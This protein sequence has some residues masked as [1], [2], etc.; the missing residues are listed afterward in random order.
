MPKKRTKRWFLRGFLCGVILLLLLFFGGIAYMRYEAESLTVNRSEVVSADWTLPPLRVAVVADFHVR[1]DPD[2][3]AR[4][5]TIVARTNAETPDL[6]LLPGDFAAGMRPG[7][8]ADPQEIA[9]ELAKLKAPLGVYAVL[10]NHDHWQKKENFVRAFGR[11]G[12]P[13]L[14][15][16]SVELEFAGKRFHLVGIIDGWTQESPDW[17]TLLPKDQLPRI[18]M[19]HTPDIYDTLPEPTALAVAGHTHGG[20]IVLPF[21]G[22]PLLPSRHHRRYASGLVT[23]GRNNVFITVGTG[24]SIVPLRFL[25]PPEIAILTLKGH[26]P[27]TP[28]PVIV[29]PQQ[30]GR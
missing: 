27:A 16:R 7:K 2:A 6:I 26:L 23:E 5:R 18:V 1:R 15:N 13:L 14:E 24:T 29:P 25:C 17:E 8:S 3:L 30:P 12:I 28:E 11:A 4:L 19:T 21:Y 9:D 22:P 20:Q 10:G